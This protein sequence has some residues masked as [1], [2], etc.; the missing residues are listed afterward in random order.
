MNTTEY[1][2]AMKMHKLQLNATRQ[3]NFID[4]IS[5]KGKRKKIANGCF[6]LYNIQKQKNEII[7]LRDILTYGQ[8]IFRKQKKYYCKSYF[9]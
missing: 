5:K 1:Y 9:M 8:I 2:M 7:F 4:L 6:H 3:T